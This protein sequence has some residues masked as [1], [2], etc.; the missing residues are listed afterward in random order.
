MSSEIFYKLRYIS[1][2]QNMHAPMSS[3]FINFEAHFWKFISAHDPN[4]AHIDF[5]LT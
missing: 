2:Y 3:Q 1:T 4:I 5:S